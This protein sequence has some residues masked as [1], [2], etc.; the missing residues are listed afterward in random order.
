MGAVDARLDRAPRG[1]RHPAWSIR[2]S[3]S[4]PMPAG[5]SWRTSRPA[6]CCPSTPVIPSFGAGSPRSP[7]AREAECRDAGQAGRH[8]PVRRLDR[9]RPR[10]RPRAHR[11]RVAEGSGADVVH[12]AEHA[13]A[14]R[15]C[16]RWPSPATCPLARRRSATSRR[17]GRAV[18][19][20]PAAGTRRTRQ[21]A[22]RSRSPCSWQRSAIMIVAFARPRDERRPARIAR[23]P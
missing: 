8:R 14:A 11:R 10:S 17:A 19:S 15:W 21:R 12:L 13:G 2:A 5:S 18:A 7:T 1:D 9:G 6:S 20:C 16:C 22:A 23:A 3:S 4:C